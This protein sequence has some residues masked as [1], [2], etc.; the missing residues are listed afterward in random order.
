MTRSHEF[1]R[2]RRFTTL[3]LLL[4]LGALLLSVTSV[5]LMSATAQADAHAARHVTHHRTRHH[6]RRHHA[7]PGIPQHNGGDHDP[8]NNGARSDGDGNQ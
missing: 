3:A 4:T 2:G 5:S 1:A 6:H 8:D 7:A